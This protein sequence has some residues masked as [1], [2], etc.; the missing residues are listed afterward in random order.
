MAI[1]DNP[2]FAAGRN[3]SPE[4]LQRMLGLRPADWAA[5]QEGGVGD[6]SGGFVDPTRQS[7]GWALDTGRF[8]P[9]LY[10]EPTYDGGGNGR[11]HDN[12]ARYATG[13]GQFRIVQPRNV[14]TWGNSDSYDVWDEQGRWQGVETDG[15][16]LRGLVN[17]G[18]LAA[19]ANN[20]P[21]AALKGAG[22]GAF[23]AAASGADY[24]DI[25]SAAARGAVT[26]TVAHGINTYGAEQGWDPAVTKAVSSGTTTALRGGDGQDILQNAA[27]GGFGGYV[28]AEGL[29]GN[30]MIDR[31]IASGGSAAIRGAD[32]QGILSSAVQGAL[33]DSKNKN[34][35][36]DGGIDDA[37]SNENVVRFDSEGGGNVSNYSE[38]DWLLEQFGG[39][40]S[41]GTGPVDDRF[42]EAN[43]IDLIGDPDYSNEGRNYVQPVDDGSNYGN[44][45]RN[46]PT[47]D[48]TQGPGG[49]P[50]NAS[51][52]WGNVDLSK[53]LKT[54]LGSDWT[55]LGLAGLAA[56]DA[57][58]QKQ[59]M[60]K[61]PWGPAQPYLKGLMADGATLYD[62]YKQT[63]FSDQQKTAYNNLGGLLNTINAN[64]GGLMS[65]FQAN[66]S[67]A[68]NYDRSNPRRQLTGSTFDMGQFMPGLLNF[69]KG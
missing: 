38:W 21:P 32:G 57:K 34:G 3:L 56:Y 46:Y 62:Q 39:G 45:G 53:L 10:Y 16:A 15:T 58:D 23:A 17:M 30:Q 4:E 47:V 65:G 20:L 49:S 51:F 33:G 5:P 59:T 22:T 8:A 36:L 37:L 26:G 35:L 42:W 43:T 29:T 54:F 7:Q 14:S 52:D 19:G 63:P 68:N 18:L 40:N 61:D 31:A 12:G 11:S 25:I 67:G 9:T 28:N 66:A 50:V 24:N 64:A 2:I 60:T 48:S 6:A 13:N 55:K 27:A 44:E 41:G 69:F 1:N